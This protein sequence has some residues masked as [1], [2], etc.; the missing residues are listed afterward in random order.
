MQDTDELHALVA[1]DERLSGLMEAIREKKAAVAHLR[2]VIQFPPETRAAHE[3]DARKTL[4]AATAR[5]RSAV[6]GPVNMALSR[7]DVRG[8]WF[9]EERRARYTAALDRIDELAG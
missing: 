8:K 7:D 3:N 1:E 5:L 6:V 9:R 4:E 2:M